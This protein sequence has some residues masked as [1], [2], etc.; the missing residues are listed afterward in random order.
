MRLNRAAAVLGDAEVLQAKRLR[1]FGH[2]L[3]RVVSIA[4]DRVAMKRAAQ[5]FLLDQL[6]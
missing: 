6:R 2:F 3:E 4:R 5:I 1:R